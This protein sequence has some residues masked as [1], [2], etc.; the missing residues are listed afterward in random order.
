[1][2]RF[3]T[4]IAKKMKKYFFAFIMATVLIG[5][6]QTKSQMPITDWDASYLEGNAVLVDVR[7]PA[8]FEAGHLED[9]VNIDFMQPDFSNRMQEFEPSQTLY[10]YCKVGGRSARAAVL[11]DSLG[12][13][14]VIDLTGGYDAYKAARKP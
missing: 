14:N 4:T 10:L 12:Y 11:L 9:A 5:C 7:T 8:E 3:N 2:R 1:M 13:K 6:S